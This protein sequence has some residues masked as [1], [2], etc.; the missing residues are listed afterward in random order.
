MQ[1][2]HFFKSARKTLP[3]SKAM[4]IKKL[5]CQKLCSKKS[6]CVLH[7]PFS[8]SG[9]F[10]AISTKRVTVSVPVSKFT[11]LMVAK[12]KGRF[13]LKDYQ[14]ALHRQVQNLKQRGMTVKEYTEEFYWVNLRVGYTKDTPEK[15]VRFGRD[16]Y[17]LSKE[18][19]RSIPE[20]HKGRRE[21]HKKIECQ[22]RTRNWY[23]K[24]TILWQRTN[25]QQQ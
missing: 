16:K 14:I 22:E 20:C 5:K 2:N 23:G 10:F 8:K 1:N 13:L 9:H 25:C 11:L 18:H 21:D 7:H 3:L 24:R 12:M 19:R 6:M 15:T 4:Y 17:F